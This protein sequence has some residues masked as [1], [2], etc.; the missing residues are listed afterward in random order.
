MSRHTGKPK[1]WAWL[2]TL[3]Y[4]RRMTNRVRRGLTGN[5]AGQVREILGLPQRTGQ[6]MPM[7]PMRR[8]ALYQR[9][10][11]STALTP[12]QRRR[13]DHKENHLIRKAAQNG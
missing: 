13:A 4:S 2:Q 6:P 7:L 12:R 1:D 5:V 11:G 10:T 9:Q 3:V 8:A